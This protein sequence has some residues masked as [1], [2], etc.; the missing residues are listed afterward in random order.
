VAALFLVP[1]ILV[2]FPLV[3]VCAALTLAIGGAA[4][5]LIGMEA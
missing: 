2:E 4:D 1:K 5:S 3:I